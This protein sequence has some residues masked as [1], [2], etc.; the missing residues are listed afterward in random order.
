M[1]RKILLPIKYIVAIL[2]SLLLLLA[3]GVLLVMY[4]TDE[5]AD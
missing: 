2:F 3:I 4:Y 5:I 1:M